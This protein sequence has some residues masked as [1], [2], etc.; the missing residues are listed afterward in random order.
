VNVG[1]WLLA[2]IAALLLAGRLYQFLGALSDR[3]KYPPP[4]RMIAG[5]RGRLHLNVQGKGEPAVFLEAGIA[6]TSLSWARIQAEVA[7]YTTTASYDRAGLGWSERHSTPRTVEN[8]LAELDHVVDASGQR[9]PLVFVGHSF[10]GYLLRHY[11]AFRPGKVAALVLVDPMDPGEWSPD[12]PGSTQKLSRGVMMSRWGGRLAG[13]GVVRL[14]L[15]SLM[16][17]SR[18]LPKLIARG[19][20]TGRGAAFTEQLVG[21]VRK[22]PPEVWPMVKAHWCEPK[23]FRGMAGYLEVLSQNSAL[24]A[25]EAALRDVPLW[26]ISGGHVSAETLEAHRSLA[27]QSRRGIHLVAEKS[28]HWV[29]LDEP[30]LVLRIIREAWESAR[31]QTQQ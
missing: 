26:V 1:L 16:A 13:V 27:R 25:D 5:S 31:A 10:G 19:V 21:Q 22:L 4:G 12:T 20:S 15:D 14:A 11:A 8:L 17:G 23:N 18:T 2:A 9:A 30:E 28:G 3:R 24:A 6:A 29:H 7:G